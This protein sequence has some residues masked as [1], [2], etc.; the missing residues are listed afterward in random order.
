MAKKNK[1]DKGFI[2]IVALIVLVAAALVFVVV[3][4][5]TP[6]NAATENN[7]ENVVDN[8]IDEGKDVVQENADAS[9]EETTVTDDTNAEVQT[10]EP[11]TTTEENAVDTAD[12]TTSEE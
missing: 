10:E 3:R 8:V 11:E 9:S 6:E 5:I 12:D 7:S 1:T 4:G 2:F